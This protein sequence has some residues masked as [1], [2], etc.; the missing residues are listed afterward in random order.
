MF[1]AFN[2]VNQSFNFIFIEES[3]QLASKGLGDL[4]KYRIYNPCHIKF[5]S[6]HGSPLR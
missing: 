5:F 2:K 3:F 6:Y 4:L 1:S